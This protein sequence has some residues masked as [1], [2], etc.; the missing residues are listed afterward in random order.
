MKDKTGQF[1]LKEWTKPASCG[2]DSL[3]ALPFFCKIPLF[4]LFWR[5]TAIVYANDPFPEVAYLR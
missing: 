1:K 3:F 4:L 2:M 5:R